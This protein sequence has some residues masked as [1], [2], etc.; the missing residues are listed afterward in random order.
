MRGNPVAQ[1]LKRGLDDV[2]RRQIDSQI[3]KI[4][5]A[6]LASAHVSV[7]TAK[8]AGVKRVVTCAPPIRRWA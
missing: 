8:V 7:V 3:G 1:W 5:E 6:A 4:V 2:Q